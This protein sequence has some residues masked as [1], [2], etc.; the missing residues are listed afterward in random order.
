MTIHK[1][2]IGLYIHATA[3]IATRTTSGYLR[4]ISSILRKGYMS[5][6][7]NSFIAHLLGFSQF[8]ILYQSKSRLI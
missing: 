7:R 8:L 4:T 6:L 2:T 3:I 1:S 5:M